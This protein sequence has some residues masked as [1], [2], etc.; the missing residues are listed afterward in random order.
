MA[1]PLLT[2]IADSKVNRS[3]KCYVKIGECFMYCQGSNFI[4]EII[5]K[6]FGTFSIA[7]ANLESVERTIVYLV[8]DC[9]IWL[10][11]SYSVFRFQKLLKLNIFCLCKSSSGGNSEMCV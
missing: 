1:L 5:K 3:L 11:I 2:I 10:V 6:L 4:S 7:V 8:T 9:I